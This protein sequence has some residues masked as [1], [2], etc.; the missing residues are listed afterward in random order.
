M[1]ALEDEAEM[2]VGYLQP[3]LQLH[4]FADEHYHGYVAI[5][6]TDAFLE[7]VLLE[8]KEGLLRHYWLGLDVLGLDYFNIE[9]IDG[10]SRWRRYYERLSGLAFLIVISDPLLFCLIFHVF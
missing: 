8:L 6:D 9:L 1:L 3:T 10:F 5:I 4:F 2:D 7:F